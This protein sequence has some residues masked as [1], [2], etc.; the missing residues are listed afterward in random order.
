MTANELLAGL[1]AHMEERVP[2]LE[3]RWG[4]EAKGESRLVRA[5][6]ITGEVVKEAYAG[7]GW[8][9]KLAFTLFLPRERGPES[10]EE[11]VLKVMQAALGFDPAP[12]GVERGA[13]SVDKHTGALTV[14]VAVVFKLGGGASSQGASCPV[15]LNGQI[16][17]AGGWKVSVG[18]AGGKLIAIGEEEPFASSLFRT[19]TIDL[20]GLPQEALA[21]PDGFSFRLAGREEVYENCRWKS[22]SAAGAGTLVSEK[23]TKGE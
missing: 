2:G 21:L 8:E 22:R 6:A 16:F 10:A 20:Q 9:A 12:A 4:W 19:Y 18:E 1:T 14:S 3:P 11:T 23:I 17:K 7:E 15:E 13:L 5:A